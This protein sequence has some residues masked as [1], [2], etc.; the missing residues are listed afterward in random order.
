MDS[1]EQN[2][3]VEPI[4]YE[5]TIFCNDEGDDNDWNDCVLTFQLYNASDD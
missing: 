2:G 3:K 1:K 4:C 5:A